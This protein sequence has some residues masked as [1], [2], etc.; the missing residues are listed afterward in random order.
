MSNLGDVVGG[1]ML[2]RLANF[3]VAALIGRLYDAPVLGMYATIVAVATL[4]ERLADNGL[5]LTG[6]AEV[7][8]RPRYVS[9]IV[10]AL[11]IDKTIL[12]VVA[13]GLL[14]TMGRIVGL[15]PS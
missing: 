9:E 11:Y 14:A 10:T 6:I 4:G 1:E 3:G 15:P 8:T 5:E 13:I 12:C 2:L 7:S